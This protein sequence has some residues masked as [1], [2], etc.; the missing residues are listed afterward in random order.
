MAEKETAIVDTTLS[1]VVTAT[2]GTA[3]P[4]LGYNSITIVVTASSVTTGG[5]VV[6]QGSADGTNYYTID[7]ISVT[8]NGS[9]YC[10]IIAEKHAFVRPNL[11]VRTDGTYTAY[12]IRGN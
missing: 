5:T 8:G 7:T 3:K 12:T 9:Q 6:I 11:T 10:S 1:A 4:C 2:A